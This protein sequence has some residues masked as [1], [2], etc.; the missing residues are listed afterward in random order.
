MPQNRLSVRSGYG[1]GFTLTEL[2]VV[3]ALVGVLAAI[4]IPT[5]RS[6]R[7]KAHVT[8]CASNLRQISTLF[9]LYKLDNNLELPP[10]GINTGGNWRIWDHTVLMSYMDDERLNSDMSENQREDGTIFQCP[11]AVVTL[12]ESGVNGVANNWGY[13]MNKFLPPKGGANYYTHTQT[14]MPSKVHDPSKT[15]IVMDAE[16]S[17]ISPNA[18]DLARIENASKRHSGSVNVLFLDGHVENIA[19]EDIPAGGSAE[20]LQFWEGKAPSPSS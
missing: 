8:E 17:I 3:I 13:G 7:E 4:L 2:L 9:E 15:A 16:H 20:G 5:V 11:T 6:V 14:K 18:V 19:F 10:P 12:D 1:H